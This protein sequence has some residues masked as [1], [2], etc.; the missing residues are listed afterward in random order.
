M[1][2]LT[3]SFGR[4][5]SS[6]QCNIVYYHVKKRNKLMARTRF[7]RLTQKEKDEIWLR[8]K[9]GE[10]LKAIGEA[11]GRTPPAVHFVLSQNGGV[12]QLTPKRSSKHLSL[13]EREEISRGLA[14]SLSIREISR[15]LNRSPSTI[16]REISRNGGQANYRACT[17]D[18][19]AWERAKR[20]QPCKLSLQPELTELVATKLM[21]FWSPEQIAGWLKSEYPDEENWQVSHETIYKSLYIQTRGV[22]KKELLK[23]LRTQPSI[24]GARVKTQHKRAAIP[25]L[26]PISERPPCVEDRAIPGHWEGDLIEGSEKSYIATLVERTTRYVNLLKVESKSTHSVVPKL[27]SHAQ[28]LPGELYKSLTWDRGTELKGHKTFTEATDIDVFFCDPQ[29]PWQRGTNE[30]TNRLLRQYFPKKTNLS[31]Y[32]QEE[33]DA[34]AKQLNERPRK[35]LGFKTPIEKFRE[36]VA[37]TT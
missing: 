33:L 29:S 4:V 21:L 35:T 9:A 3:L 8:W 13:K 10:N 32:S 27:I 28:G 2:L 23:H 30:N 31:D 7:K 37:L 11:L 26:V 34:V 14:Q 19:D 12:K 5:Q 20:P 1:L 18:E 36:C 24:R 15:K 16:S 6:R 22:L 17:A 25:D